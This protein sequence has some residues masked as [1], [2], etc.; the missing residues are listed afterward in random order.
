MD[1]F[2]IRT[3]GILI[4][5]NKEILISD[6]L[7]RG[8]LF[9]KFPGGGL[10]LGEGLIDGL[11][12][13]FVEECNLKIEKA[14]L[15]YITDRVVE[16]MFNKSQVLGVYYQVF[17]NEKLQVPIK[18]K[19]FDFEEGSEQSFRWVSLDSFTEEDLTFEMDREAWESFKGKISQ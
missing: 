12:R 11:K 10:E 18:T 5:Q 1:F 3:Y 19:P 4:N 13:E 15:L 16:S 14:E 2:S 7:Y 17:T 6:E 9:S 8:Q